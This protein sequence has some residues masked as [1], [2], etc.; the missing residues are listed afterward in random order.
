MLCLQRSNLTTP[1]LDPAHD[2]AD[3]GD[4]EPQDQEVKDYVA[5]EAIFHGEKCY[6]LYLN[7]FLYFLFN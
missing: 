7:M 5:P 4:L 6:Y 2:P 1:D 3:D